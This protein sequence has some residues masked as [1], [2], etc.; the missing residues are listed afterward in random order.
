VKITPESHAWPHF[1]S[2]LAEVHRKTGL[3]ETDV[4]LFSNDRDKV[5]HG[6]TKMDTAQAIS[7]HALKQAAVIG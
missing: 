7:V 5:P 4:Q 2:Q 1:F 3:K 6:T